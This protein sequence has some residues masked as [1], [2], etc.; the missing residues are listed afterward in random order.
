MRFRHF[1]DL[2]QDSFP[3]LSDDVCFG[4]IVHFVQHCA[5]HKC[6]SFV[7]FDVSSPDGSVKCDVLRKTLFPEVPHGKGVG[8]CEEMHHI[9]ICS[10]NVHF[11][12]IHQHCPITLKSK[13]SE[14]EVDRY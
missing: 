3:L 7:V 13:V 10:P 12:M 9:G 11:E 2:C 6:P 8:I 5:L 1:P 4:K 14:C